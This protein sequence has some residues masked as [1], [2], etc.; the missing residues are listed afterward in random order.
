MT[1]P[2]AID[3]HLL[4]VQEFPHRYRVTASGGVT[5]DVELGAT[6]LPVLQSQSPPEFD[7]PGDRWSPESLLVGAVADCF[8]L[9][10]R[11]IARASGV[12]WTSLDCE[13][14]GTLDRIDQGLQFT[15][16]DLAARLVVAREDDVALAQRAL[17]KAKRN[18]LISSSLKGVTDLHATV[19][20]AEHVQ[21]EERDQHQPAAQPESPERGV[22]KG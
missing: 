16:F 17:E 10:F 15:H 21:S 4:D 6:G 13:V 2:K 18:C 7:G 22:L 14:T 3:L 11:P 19:A 20:T 5:G 1:S 12:A 8:I 9:T